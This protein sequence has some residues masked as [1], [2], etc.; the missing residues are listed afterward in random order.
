MAISAVIF[1][2]EAATLGDNE[3]AFF[4]DVNP[5]GYILF[6]RHCIDREQVKRLVGDLKSISGRD[7]LPILIDQEG[8]RVARLK[9]PHWP[10]YPAAGVFAKI[11]ETDRER[12]HNA[13]YLNARL[14]AHDLYEIGI[15]VDCAPL[16]DLPVEGAHDIIGDRAFGRDADQVIYLARAMAMGL[17]DGGVVPVV[18]HIPGHGRATADSHDEVPVVNESLETLRTT[19]FKPFKALSNL[20]MAMTAHVVYSAIDKKM[21]T[22]SKKTIDLIR[23]EIGFKGLL[24][25]DAL[26]MRSMAGMSLDERARASL[27]AGC[28]VA[29]HCNSPLKEKLEVAKGVGELKGEALARGIRAMESIRAVKSI[30]PKTAREKLE[31][32]L[33]DTQN[34]YDI[35]YIHAGLDT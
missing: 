7:R 20:P 25:S 12:A 23:N 6:A 24:M 18:K 30:D 4:R 21:A 5:Y 34:A 33:S 19:D 35:G 11:A 9:P 10:K 29:L 13:V 2:P 22:L 27:E 17:M 32:L 26:D 8:G 1:D 16:A 3:K 28:D 15:T 14:I 31:A